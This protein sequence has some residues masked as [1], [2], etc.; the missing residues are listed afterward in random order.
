M[1]ECVTH[2]KTRYSDHPPAFGQEQRHRIMLRQDLPDVVLLLLQ[3]VD[4][5][6]SEPV[7][8]DRARQ[9]AQTAHEAASGH[10]CGVFAI[11]LGAL[12]REG[13]S[14]RNYQEIATFGGRAGT[15]PFWEFNQCANIAGMMLYT[16]IW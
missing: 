5:R 15:S 4:A 2:S 8:P 9:P 14:I 12:D 10:R 13:Q 1:S 3:H 16:S 7:A 6:P 11:G